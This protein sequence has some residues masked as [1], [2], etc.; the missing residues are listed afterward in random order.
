VPDARDIDDD[1]VLLLGVGESSDAYHVAD[2]E[3]SGRARWKPP[4]RPRP[5]ADDID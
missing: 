5:R 4:S 3:G 2:P 1:A